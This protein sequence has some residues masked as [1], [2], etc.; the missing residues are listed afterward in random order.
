MLRV[1]LFCTSVLLFSQFT[2]AFGQCSI[3]VAEVVPHY[4]SIP[5]GG[6]AEVSLDAPG[7][8]GTAY[9]L[10]LDGVPVHQTLSG[11][12]NS[13]IR[14]AVNDPGTYTVIAYQGECEQPMDEQSVVSYNITPLACDGS[15]GINPP[16][17][18]LCEG[19][20][21]SIV[22]QG[23]LTEGD[24]YNLLLEGNI[25]RSSQ[26]PPSSS[27]PTIIQ[28][29][30]ITNLGTYTATGPC[31]VSG[32]S[33]VTR[34]P[35]AE[36]NPSCGTGASID[37]IGSDTPYDICTGDN[38]SL[39]ASK[40]RSSYKWCLNVQDCQ[41][42]GSGYVSSSQSTSVS[43]SGTY[44]LY[45]PDDCG[46]PVET[47][48]PLTF[49]PE[50]SGVTADGPASRCQ[51][52]SATVYTAQGFNVDAF[53]W[54][55][56]GAGSE[57]YA[58]SITNSNLGSGQLGTST[59][60]VTWTA[61]YVGTA[62]V[63]ATAYG[64]GTTS[65]TRSVTTQT[66]TQTPPTITAPV[67]EIGFGANSVLF[68]T[69]ESAGVAYQ[70]YLEGE[71]LPGETQRT[72]YA[73]S[74]G[75]YTVET[76]SETCPSS[77][78]EPV[79]VTVVNNYNYVIVRNL[80]TA[81]KG[82]GSAVTE[83]DLNTLTNQDKNEAITYLDGL[84]RSI[85]RVGWQTTPAQ[86]DL[87]APMTYDEQGRADQQYLPYVGGNN[88]YYKID[89]P[90]AA[91][92]YYQDAARISQGIVTDTEPYATTSYEA[93]PL[94]RTQQQ[95]A[96]G[97]AFQPLTG[98]VVKYAYP[99]NDNG[100]YSA[101]K[102]T[103]GVND[104]PRST[105]PY[106]P[107]ALT[108][109]EVTD[110]DNKV[111]EVYTDKLGQVVLRRTRNGAESLD[112]YYIYDDNNNLRFVLPPEAIASE[113]FTPDEAFLN[114]WAYRY[115]FD[116]R[117]RLTQKKAPGADWQY[118][119]YDKRD[120]LILSQ[121]GRQ[122]QEGEWL[123]THYDALNRP[124]VEGLYAS[125]ATYNEMLDDVA[126][127][128][129][130]S[131]A[132]NAS[133]VGKDE[134]THLHGEPTLELDSYGGQSKITA[135]ESITLQVG[136][137]V[138]FLSD[139]PVHIK[140]P[141]SSLTT[142]NGAFPALA[143]SEVL[144][145]HYYDHY[146]FN[147]DGTADYAYN[148]EGVPS[149]EDIGLYKNV[150]GKPTGTTVRVL[151]QDAWLTT[152]LFYDDKGRVVQTQQRNHIGGQDKITTE[153]S[154]HGLMLR[155]WHHQ[156]SNETL[157]SHD[158]TVLT[159]HEY[160]HADRL[161]DVY[162]TVGSADE[163]RLAHYEY[164]EL[165]QLV[166]K[167][168][169]YDQ[170]D[171]T[172]CQSVD[173]R[174][175]VRG[176]LQSINQNSLTEGG[177]ASS[178]I[179]AGA[180][181][182][183]QEFAYNTA[184]SGM[185]SPGLFNGNISAVSWNSSNLSQAQAYRYEYDAVN[186]LQ[187][188]TSLVNNA[189]TWSGSPNYAVSGITYDKNG[190]LKTLVR[191]GAD[192]SEIDNLT[193]TYQDNNSSNRLAGVSDTN[194]GTLGFADGNNL[195]DDYIYDGSG[196]LTEDLN[197]GITTIRYNHLNLPE[198]VTL[199]DG[200]QLRYTY[201]AMGT[202]LKQE[203][204]TGGTVSNETDYVLG[205]QYKNQTLDFLVHAEGRTKFGAGSF[206]QHYDI[207]DHLGNTR[208][209]FRPDEVVTTFAATMETGGNTA[210]REEAYFENVEDSR[211]TL[212]YHNASPPSSEEPLPNKVATLN[213]AKGRV[214]GPAKSLKVHRGD[215]I[216][217][218]VQAS[219]EEH[220]RKKV[221]GGSGVLAA[222]STLFSPAAAGIEVVGASEGINEALAGATLLD[223]DKT[224]VPKAYLNYVVMNDDK[225]VIDQGFVPVSEAAKIE[226]GK[227]RTEG[228]KRE[229]GRGMANG[230]DSVAH[231]TL[232]VDLDIEEEGYLYTYVSNESNW[233]VDVHF[234]QMAVAAASTAP[235]TV[236]SQDYYPHGL[237]HQQ[238]LTT[239]TND[240]L[241]NGMERVDELDLNVYSAA[242]RT[243][244]PALGRWWQQ[245]PMQDAMP[246]LSAYHQTY[247]NPVA[248]ADPLGLWPEPGLNRHIGE[249]AGEQWMREHGMGA[250]YTNPVFAQGP[251]YQQQQM[252]QFFSSLPQGTYQVDSDD[253]EVFRLTGFS[254]DKY[255][256]RIFYRSF[257]GGG[258]RVGIGDPN[259][260]STDRLFSLNAEDLYGG[261]GIGI[262]A[263]GTYYGV[264]GNITHNDLYWRQKN[265]TLRL[266]TAATKSNYLFNRSYNLV[267]K[268][269]QG[270]KVIGNAFGAVGG[271]LTLGDIAFNGL[272]WSNGLDAAFGAAAF[273]PGVGWAISGAYFVT[274]LGTTLVT[275]KTI[276]VHIEES[277]R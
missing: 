42:N 224:G 153:Y 67:T 253:D 29:D 3:N 251:S 198:L 61:G 53:L 249:S 176:W 164:N 19:E 174:Y 225:Q 46:N 173:Y 10:F 102:W 231:E 129:V 219:Y 152:A 241:Y 104:L 230:V 245:D 35:A 260:Y 139:G 270:V 136:F 16:S 229:K 264:K 5:S 171:D 109:T 7:Q 212:A 134:L 11:S 63:Q 101:R 197:K 41:I 111:A 83:A 165:G 220:S 147:L 146:D 227:R 213:A 38:I 233:D 216:H 12:S 85:H 43:Q 267:G 167:G 182:F 246:G 23:A 75:S 52:E 215:S 14:W 133:P 82:N 108:I 145:I 121:D 54:S 210:P 20:S 37:L 187:A 181:L 122:R 94:N 266:R 33:E 226:T 247:G 268:S 66:I 234:D 204:E 196:N 276:G 86:Q 201:D 103:L 168:L 142:S 60:T 96:P 193:Y 209:T 254:A 157:G 45:T 15:I 140:A 217:I 106:D 88:G 105:E 110:E 248:F 115:T 8:P 84:G 166:D 93:S 131:P 191:N 30:N 235:L 70:W 80:R 257:F 89:A 72:L 21:M 137:E 40:P 258:T 172:Y 256:A 49:K 208:L 265:G 126:N 255:Y 118:M 159:K 236:Q 58:I 22:L 194:S 28:W 6:S 199:E 119:I 242:F 179:S 98:Q 114:R 239:P 78:S 2:S 31:P 26:V 17:R 275:G 277:L 269:L 149:E 195:G 25:I 228:G 64:C 262:G 158:L 143:N 39:E 155:Q 222:V 91:E 44:Y 154:F 132:N 141:E 113:N 169:H 218:E 211:R 273:I 123:F 183:G 243:Y 205:R 74:P 207:S 18:A 90:D 259:Y 261:L 128:L 144:K 48:I 9:R 47:S 65:T 221:K 202:K 97:A 107:G 69:E 150:Q 124:V 263:A 117:Q 13:T 100:T 160:D 81:E 180:D 271:V 237:T 92:A 1:T 116:S 188:A 223:R 274:N 151:D 55:V 200:N 4:Q 71:A 77:V 127:H 32:E 57:D 51:G 34:K 148:E 95:G 185:S 76:S 203:V 130:S 250:G 73:F 27:G 62:Q 138:D 163:Q 112:T 135:S 192:G 87:T 244:D 240:Y 79:T 162:Q 161:T 232:A 59:A 189:G 186:R 68:S 272:N 120:R 238:P 170:S 99:V 190:N 56:S 50:I 252:N 36:C 125:T 24:T 177:I 178:T 156:T 175:T 214:K 184:I 206:T